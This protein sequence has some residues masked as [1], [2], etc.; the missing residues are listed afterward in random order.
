[1]RLA[2]DGGTILAYFEITYICFVTGRL[3]VIKRGPK[4]QHQKFSV[5]H[6][7]ILFES[8]YQNL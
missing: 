1:M 8:P 7:V 6:A 3:P 2:V 4:Y 5:I